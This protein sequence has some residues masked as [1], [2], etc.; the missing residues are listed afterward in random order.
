MFTVALEQL[1][2]ETKFSLARYRFYLL[3]RHFS[4]LLFPN[5]DESEQ[6][7]TFQRNIPFNLPNEIHKINIHNIL[8]LMDAHIRSDIFF[9]TIYLPAL[10]LHYIADLSSDSSVNHRRSI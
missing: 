4:L 3:F 6:I 5:K 10:N 1:T 9:L 2:N 7:I 8:H